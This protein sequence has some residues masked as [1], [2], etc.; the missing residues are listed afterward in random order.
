[1]SN[2]LN[3]E[4]VLQI[5][6]IL[7]FIV[8][9]CFRFTI[10]P[11]Q[12]QTF[13]N[14][15]GYLDSNRPLREAWLPGTTVS[16]VIFDTPDDD[17]FN[18][19][20]NA[21]RYWNNPGTANCTLITFNE[22][23]RST[24]I[25]GDDDYLGG[26]PPDNTI[27]VTRPSNTQMVVFYENPGPNQ[28]VRAGN[29]KLRNT[30]TI[31]TRDPLMRLDRLPAHEAGHSLGLANASGNATIMGSALFRPSVILTRLER[32]TVRYQPP[33]RR[34]RRNLHRK[35]VLFSHRILPRSKEIPKTMLRAFKNLPG[36]TIV[37]A[38]G[39]TEIITHG[40]RYNATAYIT[41]IIRRS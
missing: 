14:G 1:M 35:A 31:N 23:T 13:C 25:D 5:S 36:A 40:T 26:E 21:I 32:F 3:K 4:L 29:M 15:P 34:R 37:T 9:L 33:H 8:V 6:I 20:S 22:A 11:S 41:L 24:N 17:D 19:I 38:T 39:F 28:N 27:W 16:V 18:A 2:K 10:M 30:F 7:A 12:A